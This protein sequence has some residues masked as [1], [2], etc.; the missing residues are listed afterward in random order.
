MS[1]EEKQQRVPMV[2]AAARATPATPAAEAAPVEPV[3]AAQG[4][5][6]AEG[7]AGP[8]AVLAAVAARLAEGHIDRS[9]AVRTVVAEVIGQELP[10]VGR[11]EREAMARDVAEVLLAEPSWAARL[12]ALLSGVAASGRDNA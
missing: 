11:L 12:D 3:A 9:S 4:V 7:I 1:D 6:A 5:E 10:L 8:A 2:G